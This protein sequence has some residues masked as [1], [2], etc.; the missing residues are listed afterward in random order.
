MGESQASRSDFTSSE[1]DNVL[2]Q[3]VAGNKSAL[4]FFGLAYYQENKTRVKALAIDDS[5]D[6]NGKGAILPSVE[7]VVAS[8]Y[9]PLSRPLFIYVSTKSLKENSLVKKFIEFYVDNAG[10]LA[11]EVGYVGLEKSKYEAVK[12]LLAESCLLYTSPSPRDATLS[13]MPS[14]A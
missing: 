14:S 1:D 6:E 8:Q 11:N 3:G 12:K 10:E 7:T 2:V 5:N 9:T 13:R 4:G